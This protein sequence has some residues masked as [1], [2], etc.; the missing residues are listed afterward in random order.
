MDKFKIINIFQYLVSLLDQDVISFVIT[1]LI[2]V[3]M[4]VLRP[5]N[6]MSYKPY[7]FPLLFE[8]ETVRA[9]RHEARGVQPWI[10]SSERLA[11]HRYEN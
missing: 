10:L 7:K 8:Q 1:C 4:G 9:D 6:Y 3:N 5:Y 11:V 2:W